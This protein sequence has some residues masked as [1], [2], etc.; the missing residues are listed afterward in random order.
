MGI[1]GLIP[2]AQPPAAFKVCEQA[3]QFAFHVLVM[4]KVRQA[5]LWP[6]QATF[7]NLECCKLYANLKK[8]H[9]ITKLVEVE[10]ST[11][12]NQLSIVQA[13]SSVQSSLLSFYAFRLP[14]FIIV[15]NF[16]KIIQI[17]LLAAVDSDDLFGLSLPPCQVTV[18]FMVNC[19][20]RWS[21]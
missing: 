7:F 14:P 16:F 13:C 11:F 4:P 6:H 1:W 2:K 8:L 5:E 18:C 20:Q 10:S 17:T 3:C 21:P 9:S 12:H 19:K 15:L